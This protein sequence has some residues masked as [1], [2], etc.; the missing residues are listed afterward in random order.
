MGGEKTFAQFVSVSDAVDIKL[1]NRSNDIIRKYKL[2]YKIEFH[3][4]QIG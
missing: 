3:A 4:N 1:Q 2:W